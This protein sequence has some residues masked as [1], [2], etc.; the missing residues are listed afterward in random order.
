M[1]AKPPN[2]LEYQCSEIVGT[3]DSGLWVV[4]DV[5]QQHAEGATA[6]ACI[7]QTSASAPRPATRARQGQS[8]PILRIGSAR[9]GDRR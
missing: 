1:S 7:A 6:R 5:E 4:A 8:Q 3:A 2:A 9:H